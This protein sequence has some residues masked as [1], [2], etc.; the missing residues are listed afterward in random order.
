MGNRIG[1]SDNG[2]APLPN[3][4]GISLTDTSDNTLQRNVI[5]G[6]TGDGLLLTGL[7]NPTR[8]RP[9]TG[10]WAI[11]SAQRPMVPAHLETSATVWPCKTFRGTRSE[12]GRQRSE[13]D[14]GQRTGA[15]G[16]G[17]GITGSQAIGNLVVNNNI[18]TN[19]N[20]TTDLGNGRAGVFLA[21]GA[22]H[23]TIGGDNVISGNG[24]FSSSDPTNLGG[25]GVY[26]FGAGTTANTVTGNLIGTDRSGNRDLTDSF[27][28]VL[29]YNAQVNL[30]S[31]NTISGNEW[32]GVELASD[33]TTAGA[34]AS[35]RLRASQASSGASGNLIVR[36]RIGTNLTGTAAIPNG[37]DGVY[38]NY[39]SDNIIGGSPP[40]EISFQETALPAS[41]FLARGSGETRCLATS[42]A[43]TRTGS[44]CCLTGVPISESGSLSTQLPRLIRSPAPTPASAMSARR[45]SI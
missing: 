13:R 33:V 37:L 44:C 9:A 31:D 34:A 41:K 4:N 26:I 2:T 8:R 43:S 10:S 28:G 45:M 15:R 39:A 29:I 38:I 7:G 14:L 42:S 24:I 25:A 20:A 19:G 1:T 3:G 35:R 6:N 12:D 16:A 36:N 5:S 22:N 18:G 21:D 32:A 27:I 11:S 23:N 30:V 17:V 40:T